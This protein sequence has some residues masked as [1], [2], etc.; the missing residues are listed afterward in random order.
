MSLHENNIDI[1]IREINT[2][3]LESRFSD[4]LIV[5]ISSIILCVMQSISPGSFQSIK[6]SGVVGQMFLWLSV[7]QNLVIVIIVALS[8]IPE[9]SLQTQVVLQAGVAEISSGNQTKENQREKK[10]KKKQTNKTNRTKMCVFCFSFLESF[11]LKL[12]KHVTLRKNGI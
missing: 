5:V 7:P 11:V 3:A 8:Y 10:K 2:F 6:S 4:R 1:F 12:Y 9:G